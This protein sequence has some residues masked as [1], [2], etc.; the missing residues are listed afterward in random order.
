M[1]PETY[2]QNYIFDGAYAIKPNL[3]KDINM[4]TFPFKPNLTWHPAVFAETYLQNYIFDGACAIKP[5]LTYFLRY[6]YT[7]LPIQT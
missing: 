2:L 7:N 3:T 6:Q 5:N 1:F 4:L